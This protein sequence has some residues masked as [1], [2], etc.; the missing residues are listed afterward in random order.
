MTE[1][2]IIMVDKKQEKMRAYM[3]P[4][5]SSFTPGRGRILIVPKGEEPSI[6]EV[7]LVNFDGEMVKKRVVGL[8]CGDSQK[9]IGVIIRDLDF[10]DP[11]YW[12]TES[13]NG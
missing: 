9:T 7:I 6:H 4:N 5:I 13:E 10:P 2:F 1:N 8:E 3:T 11:S 12:N